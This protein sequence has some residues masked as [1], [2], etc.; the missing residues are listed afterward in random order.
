MVPAA[1]WR[2]SSIVR[3]IREGSQRQ[4]SCGTRAPMWTS[5]PGDELHLL[6]V[7]SDA[8]TAVEDLQQDR[9]GG[10]VL[11]ELLPGSRRRTARPAR[12]P[13]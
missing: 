1:V 6:A 11:G 4:H 12:P 10:R 2:G 3:T 9:D 7:G 8:Q 13:P 5:P